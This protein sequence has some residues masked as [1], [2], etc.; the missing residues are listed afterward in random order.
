V[1][2]DLRP[3]VLSPAAPAAQVAPALSVIPERTAAALLFMAV[4]VA[5]EGRA[6]AL[7]ALVLLLLRMAPRVAQVERTAM[8]PAR[9]RSATAFLCLAAREGWV[10]QRAAVALAS[11]PAAAVAERAAMAPSSQG[12]ASAPTSQRL[13]AGPAAQA[14]SV[15]LVFQAMVAPAASEFSLLLQVLPSQT[16]ALSKEEMEALEGPRSQEV[17]PAKPVRAGPASLALA[18]PS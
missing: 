17:Q 1:E 7:V 6:A 13:P 3:A 9:Q 8:A 10:A 18:L 16:L 12:A 5:V 4:A 11:A 2:Q 15:G 14:A